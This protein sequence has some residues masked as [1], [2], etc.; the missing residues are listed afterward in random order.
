[1]AFPLRNTVAVV[2][3]AASGIGRA[4]ALALAG[5]GA[6]LALADRDGAGLEATAERAEGQGVTVTRHVFD[7]TDEAAVRAFPVGVRSAHGGAAVLVNNAGASL[8]GRFEDVSLAE[9]RWLMEVNFFSVVALTQGFLPLLA[10]ADEGRVVNVSSTFGIVAPAEQVA[11][12]SSKFAVRGFS[13]ALRHELEDTSVGVTVVHPGGVRTGIAANSRVAARADPDEAAR[14][15][16]TFADRALRI[17]PEV[18]AEAIVRGVERRRA[19]V[20]IGADARAADAV[21]RLSP[22]RYWSVLRG[23]F[24]RIAG[25][26]GG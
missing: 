13:E 3:G 1:M 10:E 19:R 9:F 15:T 7:V 2:T 23:Q 21:A 24:E 16:E 8:I 26:D 25:V 6:H 17:A 4:T 18:A 22:A 5:R 12:A 20:L 11:Y 14:K